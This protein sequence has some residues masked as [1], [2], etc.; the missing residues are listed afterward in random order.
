MKLSLQ[1]FSWL[2][3]PLMAFGQ[4]D[5]INEFQSHWEDRFKVKTG[6]FVPNRNVKVRADGSSPNEEIDFDE[7]FGFNDNQATF[8]FQFDWRF[9]RNKKW[10]FSGEY[11]S[12]NNA[13]RATLPEDVEFQDV[14]FKEGSFVRAGVDF[15]LFRSFFSYAFIKKPK[16][17]LGAGFGLHLFQVGAFI[18]GEVLT[19][20]GDLEFERRRV[21]AFLPLPN[22]GGYYI[23]SPHER[24]VFGARV[25][26]F[27][28][29]I[30]KYSGGLW[31]IAPNVSFQIF[32][33]FGV[34]LDYRFFFLNAKIAQDNWNGRFEMDFAGPLFTIYGN[35]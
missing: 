29:T 28:I 33:N 13:R 22:I 32:R 1:L 31:N 17:L 9:S 18:E 35:F 16:H 24:W 20:Q 12:V 7:A 3:L 8:F 6:I 10:M 5:S 27:G 19:N 30:D 11:F 21:S 15:A 26:W 34:A 4:K 25:D 23:Y 2:V 14:V